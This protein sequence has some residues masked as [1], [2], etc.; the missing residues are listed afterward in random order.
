MKRHMTQA[1][2]RH[3]LKLNLIE[4]LKIGLGSAL[5]IGTAA[6]LHLPNPA[7]TGTIT[8][9]TLIAH[10]RR[11]TV[12]LILLRLITFV[13]TVLLCVAIVP[14]IRQ[15]YFAYAI[16][17]S[18]IVLIS[19][20]LGWQAT[21][22]VNAVVAGQFVISQNLAPLF[23]FQQFVLLI[24]G[25]SIALV[26][27]L[28]QPDYSEREDLVRRMER[29]EEELSQV[30]YEV[31]QS[32]LAGKGYKSRQYTLPLL[33]EELGDAIQAAARY[34]NN[35][36]HMEDQWFASYFEMC[37]SQCALLHGLYD[38]TGGICK[39]T[40]SSRLLAD[41]LST[42]IPCITLPE[43]P[44][45]LIQNR[46][47]VRQRIL[48]SFGEEADY[49]NDAMLLYILIDLEEFLRLK[50]EYISSLTPKE[51]EAYE[52][53]H[54]CRDHARIWEEK[55]RQEQEELVVMD[56]EEAVHLEPERKG[57]VLSSKEA[58]SHGSLSVP[59]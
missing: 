32:L 40:R 52:G 7:S 15:P 25:I 36:F 19:E 38:H 33:K 5:A 12:E 4:A 17:L 9:L 44:I 59:F 47:V 10:T 27:N 14:L 20:I 23:V 3:E 57:T 55:L 22:S 45:P 51:F 50:E 16:V 18:L 48:D 37:L 30:L 2:K 43:K 8:L 24:I 29:V 58:A 56:M 41:Y 31:Y 28:I 39:A 1:R 54:L 42:I 21:L 49:E 13:M 35:S 46:Q 6:L 26:F 34:G 11:G 53:C